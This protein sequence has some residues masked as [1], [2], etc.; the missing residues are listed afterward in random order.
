MSKIVKRL[1]N[2]NLYNIGMLE[3]W[4][5]DM[6]QDGLVLKRVGFSKCSFR[7]TEACKMEYRIEID[8]QSMSKERIELYQ[9]CGWDF[10]CTYR[11]IHVFCA[12]ASGELIEIHTDPKEQS[13]TLKKV[14]KKLRISNIILL[15]CIVFMI[16]DNIFLLSIGNTPYLNFLELGWQS[17]ISTFV[18]LLVIM[19]TVH[20][21]NDSILLK[22]ML[23]EGKPIDHHANWKKGIKLSKAAYGISVFFCLL[24]LIQTGYQINNIAGYFNGRGNYNLTMET[25]LPITRLG[26]IEE[27]SNPI[28]KEED[29]SKKHNYYN[30]VQKESGLLVENYEVRETYYIADEIWEGHE[31]AYTP[32]LTTNYYEMTIPIFVDGVVKDLVYKGENYYFTEGYQAVKVDYEGLDDAYYIEGGAGYF[33]VVVRKGN[34]ILSLNYWGKQEYTKVLSALANTLN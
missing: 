22:K 19:L 12:P 9:Q 6:A 34:K 18:M 29:I 23:T 5:S 1:R 13:Y 10:V 21:S 4:L 17:V 20:Q 28:L 24:T 14:I 11:E 16:V 30:D 2:I 27:S 31:E 32:S 26:D 3:S 8:S 33:T 15:V 7:E 25:K